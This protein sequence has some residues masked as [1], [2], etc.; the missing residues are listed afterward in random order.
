MRTAAAADAKHAA[1]ENLEA[2]LRR[3]GINSWSHTDAVDARH[4]VRQILKHA[5]KDTQQRLGSPLNTR[6]RARGVPRSASRDSSRHSPQVLSSATGSPARSPAQDSPGAAQRLHTPIRGHSPRKAVPEE[7]EVR[8]LKQQVKQ[9]EVQM[10]ELWQ[11]N[12]RLSTRV[13]QLS[14]RL[15]TSPWAVGDRSV[16]KQVVEEAVSEAMQGRASGR[17]WDPVSQSNAHDIDDGLQRQQQQHQQHQ[18]HQLK[19]TTG[20]VEKLGNGNGVSDGERLHWAATRIQAVHR[21][22]MNRSIGDE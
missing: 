13:D 22:K 5:R 4:R 6:R 18:Q 11:D 12:E 7:S 14:S 10:Q 20:G 1:K 8:L 21:G 16:L 3:F 15:E 2:E 19:H 9:L 17:T